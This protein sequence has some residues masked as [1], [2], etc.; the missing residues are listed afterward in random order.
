MEAVGV[1][2]RIREESACNGT[3]HY[4]RVV[5]ISTQHV[6]MILFIGVLYHLE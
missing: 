4:G 5:L 1:V 2:F 3:F 6:I